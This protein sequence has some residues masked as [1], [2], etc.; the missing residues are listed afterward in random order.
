M[1]TV[2]IMFALLCL[3]LTAVVQAAPLVTCSQQRPC[4]IH[5]DANKELDL[6]G[7]G[8]YLSSISGTY[9]HTPALV[10]PD[11]ILRNGAQQ[12]LELVMLGIGFKAGPAFAVVTAFDL[13]GNESARSNEIAF[14]YDSPPLAPTLTITVP[15]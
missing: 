10:I 11:S 6:Q 14:L 15:K 8:L 1:R 3:G 4:L 7:Y 13:A 5:W 12:E 9:S 2:L